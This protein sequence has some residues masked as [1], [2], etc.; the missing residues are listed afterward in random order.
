MFR[1]GPADLPERSFRPAISCSNGSGQCTPWNI[2]G[3]TAHFHLQGSVNLKIAEYENMGKKNV[4]NATIA[5]SFSEGHVGAGLRQ[6][7]SFAL[8]FSRRLVL[9]SCN[10]YSQWDTL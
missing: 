2:C 6:Y 3:M 4:P 5:S 10:L 9:R 8:F 7:L 1:V